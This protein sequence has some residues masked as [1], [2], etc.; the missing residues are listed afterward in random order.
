MK[1]C[2]Q[3]HQ[4]KSN[5]KIELGKL[6]LIFKVTKAIQNGS[7]QHVKKYLTYPDQIWYT[8][9]TG[10]ETRLVKFLKV[11]LSYSGGV[12]LTVAIK[13]AYFEPFWVALLHFSP[14]VF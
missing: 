4:G 7:A 2:T 11:A 3:K 9:A 12:S 5:T 1:F 14:N 8:K 10:Q 13:R 6:D